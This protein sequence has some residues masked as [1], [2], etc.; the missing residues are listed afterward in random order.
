MPTR[1]AACAHWCLRCSVGTTTTSRCARRA[2]SARVAAARAKVVF[3]APG[4]ATARKLDRSLPSNRSSAACCQARSRMAGGRE[5]SAPGRGRTSFGEGI[6]L[7]PAGSGGAQ[8]GQVG[9]GGAHPEHH[10][11]VLV[12]LFQH[13][14]V[15]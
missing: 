15:G 8:A 1:P 6:A 13:L 4:V 11:L 3:P 9:G 14:A 2:V 7:A 10:R 5:R 12:A